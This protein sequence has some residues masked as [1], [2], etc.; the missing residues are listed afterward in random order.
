MQ[1]KFDISVLD[2]MGLIKFDDDTYPQY[3]QLYPTTI[4]VDE[5]NARYL[6]G[7]VQDDTEKYKE[8]SLIDLTR[9]KK[10]KIAKRGRLTYFG[11]LG[12]LQRILETIFRATRFACRMAND[13][14]NVDLGEKLKCKIGYI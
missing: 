12:K 7:Y 9:F 10:D 5:D 3:I 13:N 11:S 14:E 6:E 2:V 8:D 4:S 1:N